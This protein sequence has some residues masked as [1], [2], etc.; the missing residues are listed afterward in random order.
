MKASKPLVLSLLLSST[1]LIS[2]SSTPA[3]NSTPIPAASA[4]VPANTVDNQTSLQASVER[5]N[6]KAFNNKSFSQELQANPNAVLSA[7]GLKLEANEKIKVVD[8]LNE[9]GKVYLILD[10]RNLERF[11]GEQLKNSPS[12]AEANE[13]LKTF[14]A[15]R[16]KAQADA[17]FKASL[18]ADPA[19]VLAAEGFNAEAA[20]N[21]EVLD[22]EADTHFFL[23]LPPDQQVTRGGNA[24]AYAFLIKRFIDAIIGVVHTVEH[25]IEQW[26]YARAV[27]KKELTMEQ[28][29]EIIGKHPKSFLDTEERIRRVEARLATLNTAIDAAFYA[30]EGGCFFPRLFGAS[31][32]A[33]REAVATTLIDGINMGELIE[34]LKPRNVSIVTP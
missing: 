22:F 10:D 6:E 5:I 34:A 32:G 8:F 15:I 21:F 27:A 7:E 19:T 4:S 26:Q 24:E 33:P 9:A 31:C 2:C 14:R 3:N 20:K 16:A 28:V 13:S 30:I 18:L 11:Y 17:E 1:V 29:K 25:E 12:D 23:V